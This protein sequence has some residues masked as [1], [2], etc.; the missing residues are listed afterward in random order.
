MLSAFAR[1]S[2]RTASTTSTAF[3]ARRA[4]ALTTRAYATEAPIPPTSQPPPRAPP[5]PVR[6]HSRSAPE[7]D[8]PP[9]QVRL[10]RTFLLY[11]RRA[12]DMIRAASRS[13]LRSRLLAS[14]DGA[15]SCSLQQMLRSSQALS[16]AVSSKL[17]VQTTN[18]VTFSG[19]RFVPYRSG[20]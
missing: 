1:H 18:C 15:S 17:S 8:L 16:R 12:Y 19:T 2:A 13:W 4:L 6:A 10:E 9:G 7:R 20:G 5:A 3:A 14:V 11:L